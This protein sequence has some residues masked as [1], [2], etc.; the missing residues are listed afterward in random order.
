M[1]FDLDVYRSFGHY[2]CPVCFCMRE[3]VTD[4]PQCFDAGEAECETCGYQF[5]TVHD[6]KTGEKRPVLKPALVAEAKKR[7]L[8]EF[9]TAMLQSGVRRE[10]LTRVRRKTTDAG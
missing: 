5:G 7:R 4:D 2:H 3:F 10:D 9:H 6:E 8:E 1:A